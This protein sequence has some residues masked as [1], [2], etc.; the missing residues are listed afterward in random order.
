MTIQFCF[1]ACADNN[2]FQE[3]NVKATSEPNHTNVFGIEEVLKTDNTE[4]SSD[5]TKEDDSEN[6]KKRKT[7]IYF[8]YRQR[9]L[10]INVKQELTVTKTLYLAS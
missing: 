7:E 10:W 4:N 3:K 9:N 8:K 5:N 2:S 6:S 1:N